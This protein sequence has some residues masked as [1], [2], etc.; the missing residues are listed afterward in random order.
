MSDGLRGAL[1]GAA[2]ADHLGTPATV[3]AGTRRRPAEV[4]VFIQS[5]GCV[6]GHDHQTD[7]GEPIDLCLECSC[8]GYEPRCQNCG[9]SSYGGP[10]ATI[11]DACSRRCQL[12]L[13]YAEAR[14]RAASNT[15]DREDR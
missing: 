1:S 12:Q 10:L 8:M 14:I 15:Q 6:C 9:E 2:A 11:Y 5:K 3:H 4:V 7:R 13:E